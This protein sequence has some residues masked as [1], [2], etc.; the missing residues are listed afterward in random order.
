MNFHYHPILGLQYAPVMELVKGSF[1]WN[2][3]STDAV[4][5]IEKGNGRFNFMRPRKSIQSN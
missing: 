1:E 3:Y 2:F 4:T 5:F